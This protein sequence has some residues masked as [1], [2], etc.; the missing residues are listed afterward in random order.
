MKTA[1]E[2]QN[3]YW[4]L[5]SNKRDIPRKENLHAWDILVKE[6]QLDAYKAGMREA[7]AIASKAFYDNP[8]NTH[9]EAC[10]AGAECAI[11]LILIHRDEKTT[12][13]MK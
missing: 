12:E 1:E 7:A 10:N 13:G 4:E 9:E 8:K 6:I 11:K 5:R 3:R 2:W